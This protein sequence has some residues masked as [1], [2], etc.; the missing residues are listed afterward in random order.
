MTEAEA[1][2]Y[3][4]AAAA[5]CD[6]SANS[7]QMTMH[8]RQLSS[9]FESLAASKIARDFPGELQGA[10]SAATDEE[11]PK[12]RAL[13]KRIVPRLPDGEKVLVFSTFRDSQRALARMLNEAGFP[14]LKLIDTASSRR[15]AV[16][17]RFRDDP[18]IRALVCGEGAGEGL[19]LQF[20][21]VLV[22]YDLPWNPMRI[23]QRIGR[24]QRLGQKRR[25]VT[26]VNLAM[27]ETIED[28]IL[29][30]LTEKLRMFELLMGQTEQILGQLLTEEGA[31]FERWIA[32]ALRPDGG[33]NERVMKA[34]EKEM[35]S[36]VRRADRESRQ[37]G[38]LTDDLVGVSGPTGEEAGMTE[39]A[40]P[41]LDLSYL[42]GDW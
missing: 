21:S 22:N 30:I 2:L 9:S 18:S 13:L 10:L 12:A 38:R 28:R 3:R 25:K 1:D 32:H 11:H 6:K 36:A 37:L 23:E 39:P 29:L 5:I 15:P 19:N 34:R 26:V 20:C 16:I 40:I 8:L 4:A 33:V 31:S 17:R 41:E 7:F 27:A 35:E 42:E 24:V 14:A